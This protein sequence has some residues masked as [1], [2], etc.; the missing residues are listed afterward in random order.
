MKVYRISKCNYV[1][2]LSG[3]GASQFPGRWHNK[4][5]YVLYTASSPSLAMLESLVHIST[6][7][8]IE[9]C[10]ICL[11]I[12][13]N[14]IFEITA[15][16]LSENWF[17]N[18]PPDNLKTIGDRFVREMEFL[19]LR[20]PSAVVQEE[21]NYLLNPAH[22]FFNRVKVIYSRQIRVDERLLGNR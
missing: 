5:T 18:P 2:D 19:A 13:E 1:D 15:N 21:Y 9:R 22:P 4:G 17:V 6:V 20:V 14:S 7:I 16:Q 3:T 10:M 8:K 11:E 12:P